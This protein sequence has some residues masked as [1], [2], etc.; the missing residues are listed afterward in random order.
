MIKRWLQSRSRRFKRI[1]LMTVDSVVISIG[2]WAAFALRLGELWPDML[3]QRWW[4]LLAM[5]LMSI[6]VFFLVGMYQPIIRYIGPSFIKTVAVG[7]GLSALTIPLMIVLVPQD[8]GFPRTTPAIYF[9]VVAG[10]LGGFRSAAR[11]WFTGI[12]RTGERV[13]VYGAGHAGARLV[14]A[15]AH[16]GGHVAAVVDDSQSA[17][18]ST[19]RGVRVYSPNQ[20]V[21]IVSKMNATDV[22]LAIPSLTPGRR[23]DII[24]SL[25]QLPVHVRTVPDLDELVSGTAGFT[26]LRYLRIEDLL[27]REAVPPQQELINASVAGRSVMVTGAGGSIGSELCRGIIASECSRLVLV[28]RSEPALFEIYSSIQRSHP[29]VDVYAVLADVRDTPAI[30][31]AMEQQEVQTVFHAAAHKHVPLV[32]NH[33]IEAAGNNIFGTQSVMNAAANSGVERFVLVSTDK[34]VRPT[35]VMGATKRVAEM[36]IQAMAPE[37]LHVCMVRFGNVLGSSGSVVPIFRR[38]LEEGGPITVTDPEMVRYFMTIPEAANLVIQSGG[39]AN[40]GEVLLLDMGKPIKIVDLARLMIRL[41][42]MT[43]RNAQHPDGDIEIKFVGQRGGEK[44]REELLVS[45]EA[46][47]TS[48]PMIFCATEPAP[49][50]E[51][52]EHQLE[53][54]EA[55]CVARDTKVARQ[56]LFETAAC[57]IPSS[58]D[59]DL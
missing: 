57:G 52:L 7:V 18:G 46:L 1:I 55:A 25:V 56:I 51:W 29:T 30:Q 6:P 14:S 48:H 54:I 21:D 4:L 53:M 41:A 47:E 13:I 40:S 15:L 27:G 58:G 11:W 2:L 17:Q 16:A 23:R 31:E 24:E 36:V 44:M 12:S 49:T 45:E 50:V 33:E 19:I 20:L 8:V 22:L 26:D 32:E 9:L 3:A 39:M 59:H 35:S 5:P 42:G 34:A 38:Q 43:E 10:A 37:R 28:D